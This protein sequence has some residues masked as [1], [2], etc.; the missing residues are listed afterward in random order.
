MTARHC[1]I[2]SRDWTMVW[3]MSSASRSIRSYVRSTESMIAGWENSSD[4]GAL[5]LQAGAQLVS[6]PPTPGDRALAGD[7]NQRAR[8]HKVAQ[9]TDREA[10][11][12]RQCGVANTL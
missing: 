1:R 4:T 7:G 9:Q 6:Q 11:T 10:V 3:R 8:E 2:C 5:R 12:A